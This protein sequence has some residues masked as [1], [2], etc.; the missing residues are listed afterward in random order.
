MK[1]HIAHQENIFKEGVTFMKQMDPCGGGRFTDPLT[2]D[3][4]SEI[5]PCP[6]KV[7]T[8]STVPNQMPWLNPI[9]I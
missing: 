1:E 7:P 6:T 5:P 9:P 3:N 2:W 8:I 4:A